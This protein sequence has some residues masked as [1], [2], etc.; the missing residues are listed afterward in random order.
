MSKRTDMGAGIGGAEEAVRFLVVSSQ[1]V[2]LLFRKERE[3]DG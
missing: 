1:K 2:S 3:R